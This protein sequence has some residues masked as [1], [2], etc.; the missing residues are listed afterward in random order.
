MSALGDAFLEVFSLF[1]AFGLFHD[2]VDWAGRVG[3]RVSVQYLDVDDAV[4][5]WFPESADA[6]VASVGV[7]GGRVWFW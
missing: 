1:V 2:V 4:G 7:G 3:F 5:A 6:N